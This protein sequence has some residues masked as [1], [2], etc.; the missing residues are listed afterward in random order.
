MLKNEQFFPKYKIK[1]NFLPHNQQQRN[2][3]FNIRN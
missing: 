2:T 3:K 1:F